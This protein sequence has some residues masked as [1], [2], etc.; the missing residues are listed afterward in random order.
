MRKIEK[1][2]MLAKIIVLL[3]L[4]CLNWTISFIY[5][6]NLKIILVVFLGNILVIIFSF[7]L[8]RL[9]FIKNKKK[10]IIVLLGAIFFTLVILEIFLRITYVPI[11]LEW[12]PEEQGIRYKHFPNENYLNRIPEGIIFRGKS[13]S[14]GFIDN[15]FNESNEFNIFLLGDSFAECAQASRE[16]CLHRKLEKDLNEYYNKSI[17]VLNFGIGGYGTLD[18]V[19]IL[20][21]YG[22]EY[23]PKLVIVYFLAQNDLKDNEAYLNYKYDP[24]YKKKQLMRK[25]VP[26]SISFFA[27]GI[28]KILDK[29]LKSFSINVFALEDVNQYYGVYLQE[30]PPEWEELMQIQLNALL[31]IKEFCDQ[32]KIPM[33]V[34]LI[35]SAEQVYKEDWE[36]LLQT[37]PL[38]KE[39]EYNLSKPNIVV[40]NFL[41][42]QNIYNINLLDSFRDNPER[43]HWKYDGHWNDAGQ[44]FAEEKV[45]EFII[46]N[47]L[48]K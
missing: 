12:L 31:E 16:N 21:N 33:F 14:Q 32:K 28:K 45:K 38:L 26:R 40:E 48:I 5:D 17:D 10:E 1:K 4:I 2:A 47:N 22:E 37:Y 34:V 7:I 25:I 41:N 29:T 23:H 13:N 42:E 36:R 8:I 15:D 27:N 6:L 18:Y 39:Q 24:N 46:K 43:L 35:T 9:Y 44:L 19:G 30:Y 3:I 11:V 20:K